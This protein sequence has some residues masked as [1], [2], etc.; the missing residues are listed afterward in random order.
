[1]AMPRFPS[2]WSLAACFSCFLLTD[3]NPITPQTPPL[4]FTFYMTYADMR[5]ID[6]S[7]LWTARSMLENI[8]TVPMPPHPDRHFAGERTIKCS[9]N[10]EFIAYNFTN[11]AQGEIV[12]FV[13]TQQTSLV[14]NCT[15]DTI[16]YAA[17]CSW[18][19]PSY[20]PLVALLNIC[21]KYDMVDTPWPDDIRAALHERNVRSY[22]HELIHIM[23]MIS[24][25]IDR[26][27]RTS[28]PTRG[29]PGEFITLPKVVQW[30]R[31][32]Y[33]C[34]NIHGV[35]MHGAHWDPM[36]VGRRE[37]MTR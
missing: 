13:F 18:E 14:R 29:W 4:R 8:T 22:A 6:Q 28:E 30:A 11:I 2:I 24:P 21:P 5:W 16:A 19:L 9:P 37:L 34:E 32:H 33:Q 27:Q 36:F 12:V 23:G 17:W 31:S 25:M 26:F 10:R 1:M 20:M 15:G 7:A 35:P 3:S